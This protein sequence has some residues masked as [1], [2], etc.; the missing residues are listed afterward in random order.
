[1]AGTQLQPRELLH[2][3]RPVG[4]AV[5]VRQIAAVRS[6]EDGSLFQQSEQFRVERV[7]EGIPLFLEVTQL[8]VVVALGQVSR[9]FA[10]R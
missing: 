4:I 6:G 8:N 10:Q 5:A 3:R 2:Q 7:G 1:L 9:A